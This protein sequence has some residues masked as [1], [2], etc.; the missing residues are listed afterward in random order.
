MLISAARRESEIFSAETAL[1]LSL[2]RLGVLLAATAFPLG[3]I[4]A[5]IALSSGKLLEVG[6]LLLVATLQYK[7]V[8]ALTAAIFFGTVVYHARKA[9][10][11]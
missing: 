7:L 4:Y 2:R 1:Y 6:A 5:A 11:N 9:F 10:P 3:M 8:A